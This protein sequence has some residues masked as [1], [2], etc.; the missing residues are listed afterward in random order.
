[1]GSFFFHVSAIA[2]LLEAAPRYAALLRSQYWAPERLESY[3]EQQ[4]ERTLRAAMKIPFYA[5]RLGTGPRPGDLRHVPLLKRTEVASLGQSVRSLYPPDTSFV[6]ERSS[7]TSGVS[8]SLLFDSSHQASRNA[9]RIRYLR[10]H[11]WS[12]FERSV[13]F[14][15]ASLLAENNPDYQG[16]SELIKWFSARGVKFLSTYVPSLEQVETLATLRPRSLYAFPSGIDGISR[17]LEETGRSLPFLRLVMC[18]GEAVDDSLRERVRRTLGLEL[19][20][21]YGS[22][23]AF[24]AFQCPAGSYH[25][26]AEHVFVE[27]VDEAGREAAPGKMG[28]VLVTT[29]ENYLMPL[30]RYEIGDYAVAASGSCACGRTL[31][32]LERVLGRQVNMFRKPDGSLTS[33]WKAVATLRKFPEIRIFQVVQKSIEQICVRYV[34]DRRL[35]PECEI[36]I[37]AKFRDDLGEQVT[38]AFDQVAEI[39]RAPSGK[40]MVTMSQVPR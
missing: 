31:P 20:D 10:A 13:W 11:G 19:R 12:P 37:I 27:I 8:V 14:V 35:A 22:T 21:N 36:Q 3:R 6:G 29:L 16:V 9:A 23:E 38:V 26:N 5:D 1:L 32:L 25:I 40:F 4:L 2:R 24:V 39:E 18:G 34:A 15:G 7:G 17:A 33:G 30:V 28:R